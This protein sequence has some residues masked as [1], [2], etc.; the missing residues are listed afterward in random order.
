MIWVSLGVLL[1]KNT[2]NSGIHKN[3]G[4]PLP[5]P[6]FIFEVHKT[7]TE[8]GLVGSPL[9]RNDVVSDFDLHIP[10]GI[11]LIYN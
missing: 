7:L 4:D 10:P 6:S 9:T 3:R 1:R 8:E 11:L 5:T 2:T